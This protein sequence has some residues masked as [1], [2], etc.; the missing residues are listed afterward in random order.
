[1]PGR[2]PGVGLGRQ[3]EREVGL[4]TRR[5]GLRR[6]A[7]RGCR[8]QYDG[9]ARSTSSRLSANAG[10]SAIASATIATRSS[11]GLTGRPGLW[12]GSRLGTNRTRS[13]P[14]A[15]RAASAI[16]R[17]PTWIGSNVPPRMPSEPDGPD[18]T[19]T[20]AAHPTSHGL[21]IPL[22]LDGADP[23]RVAGA[24]SPARRSSA[25]DAEPGQVA[26][27]PVGRLVDVEVGLGGDP[28]DP[29]AA[30]PERAVRLAL[31]DEAVAERFDPMDDDAGRLDRTGRARRRPGS[32]SARSARSS[33]MPGPGRRG[34]RDAGQ[35]VAP[36]GVPEGGPGG[37]GRG[38]VDLVEGDDHRL[39]EER[40][41]VGL[42]LV[43]DDAVRPLGIAIGAVD[44]VDED[45][46]PLDVAQEG[47][48]EAGALAGAL[49]EARDV[50]DRRPALVLVAEVEHAE[51]RL[52]RRERVVGDLRP[53]RRERREE[54]R[55]A[56]IRQPDEARRRRSAGARAGSSAPRRARPSGR[57][58]AS[59]G[60]R[61]RSGRCRGRRGR[62]GRPSPP[63]RPRRGRPAARRSRRRRRPSRAGPPRIRSAAGLA[64]ASRAGPAPPDSALKWRCWR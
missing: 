37:L 19:R 32:R 21:A 44:D 28:L 58:S 25:V 53:C 12:T 45:P 23:D 13:R 18:R 11:A 42:E 43:A 4:A 55:L 9:P 31:D 7:P 38:S 34:D 39:R 54:G 63:A 10:L 40:R 16:A 48:A 61:S 29:P 17:W 64:V 26:L 27:E 57:A 6:R 47:V 35:P 41:V 3:D 46:G 49:D 52:E 24:R 33:G 8:P 50:G 15:S 36:P 60:S 14:S 59:G 51:V 5:P 1:M 62:R 20:A 56:G 2:Q 30:D 22:E